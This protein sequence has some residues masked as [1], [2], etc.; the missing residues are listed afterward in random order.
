MDITVLASSSKGNAYLISDGQT[1][2]LL[3][4]G[5]NIQ[6][7]QIKSGFRLCDVSGCLITHSH[8]DHVKAAKD[9]LKFGIDV[10]ISKGESERAG[11]PPHHRLHR[12]KALQK[13]DVGTF[14]VTPFDV[15]HDTPEPL[16]FLVQSRATKE[17]LLY[18]TDTYY[19]KYKFRNLH[20]IMAECN[21]SYDAVK[22][23]VDKGYIPQSLV[24]RLF[25]SHMSVE[26]LVQMLKANDLSNIKQIYLLH[27]SENNSRADEF[28]KTIQKVTGAE[29]YIC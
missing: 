11:L 24:P 2:L 19:I 1:S 6:S 29:V 9:L 23:S 7:L 28:K 21:Y 4:A 18:F 10:Y 22:E 5:I 27:L 17:N 20:Y 12:V 15:Q 13:F 14:R 8:M 16:G 25:K 26:H 3:D